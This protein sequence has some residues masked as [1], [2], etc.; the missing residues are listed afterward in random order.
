MTKEITITAEAY[1]LLENARLPGEDFN[2]TLRRLIKSYKQTEF[3]NRQK[4]ILE[5][6]DFTPLD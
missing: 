1:I 3:L 5:N 4:Q 2:D 6:D